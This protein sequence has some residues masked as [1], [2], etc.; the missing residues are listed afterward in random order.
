[1]STR[2]LGLEHG[3]HWLLRA[4]CGAFVLTERAAGA[5]LIPL[6]A[7][8]SSCAV[9]MKEQSKDSLHHFLFYCKRRRLIALRKKAPLRD[10][11]AA[12]VRSCRKHNPL[13]NIKPLGEWND[14]DGAG[15]V[16]LLLGGQ[17]GGA[18]AGPQIPMSAIRPKDRKLFDRVFCGRGWRSAKLRLAE[19]ALR[20]TARFLNGAMP[21]RNRY[22][23]ASLREDDDVS[24]QHGPGGTVSFPFR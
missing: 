4:R 16:N 14:D 10:V 19:A 2:H 8:G 5:K 6:P 11:A 20:A 21:T 17:H 15:Y 22:L 12:I 13:G 7:N 18:S 23:W 1:M 24:I 3:W 9:C